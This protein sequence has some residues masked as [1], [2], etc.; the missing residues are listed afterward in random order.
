MVLVAQT[1]RPTVADLL[2]MPLTTEPAGQG[3]P[4][5]LRAHGEPVQLQLMLSGFT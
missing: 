5:T 1:R 4:R 2:Q 3:A